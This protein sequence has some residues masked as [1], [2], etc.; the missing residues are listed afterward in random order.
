MANAYPNPFNPIAV[1]PFELGQGGH[2]TLTVYDLLGR[3]VAVLLNERRDAGYHTA[4]LDGSR[5][6]TGLYVVRADVELDGGAR[7][8]RT[9]RVML[10]K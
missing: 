7:G 2:V 4:T 9:Q 5:L 3:R 10:L 6:A 1:I 8:S